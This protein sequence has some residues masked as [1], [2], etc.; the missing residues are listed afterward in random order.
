MRAS[1]IVDVEVKQML[2]LKVPGLLLEE[3]TTK[4]TKATKNCTFFRGN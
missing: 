1:H 4:G 3:A 2:R